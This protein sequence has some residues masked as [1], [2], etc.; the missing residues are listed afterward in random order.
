MSVEIDLADIPEHLKDQ[1]HDEFII[2]FPRTLFRKKEERWYPYSIEDGK[3]Y[4]PLAEGYKRFTIKN[5]HKTFDRKPFTFTRELRDYQ[6]REFQ[7]ILKYLETT[8]VCLVSLKTGGG[9]TLLTVALMAHLGLNTL[10]VT[11]RGNI[12]EQWEETIDESTIDKEPNGSN[13]DSKSLGGLDKTFDQDSLSV[14]YET[15]SSSS[16]QLDPN[17][18]IHFVSA[19]IFTKLPRS[20]FEGIGLLIIDEAHAMLTEKSIANFLKVCPEYVLALT[21]TPPKG[22]KDPKSK[23]VNFFFGYN[24]IDLKLYVPG[25][26]VYYFNTSFVP[27]TTKTKQ[28]YLSWDSV[29][30]S[31]TYSQEYNDFIVD[32]VSY[33]PTRNIIILCKMKDQARYLYEK[34]KANGDTVDVYYG[35]QKS[36]DSTARVLVTTVSKSGVGFNHPKL[37]MLIMACD[38]E[39]LFLQ[40]LGR[41][42]RRPD[43]LPIIID[44]VHDLK[45]LNDHWKTRRAVYL[46]TG[47]KIMDFCKSYKE[48]FVWRENKG[49]PEIIFEDDEEEINTPGGSESTIKPT[50][51]ESPCDIKN[52]IPEIE[53]ID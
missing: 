34:I 22:A 33:F 47:G 43:V 27:E 23:I 20:L 17:V 41:V 15:L 32:L 42:F 8:S 12:K 7:N 3:I 37:D 9:K 4:L 46:E 16:T 40:Y 26:P 10:V 50:V 38:V 18:R 2:R 49:K 19:A 31:I 36:Y 45:Q 25:Y 52:K 11:H 53:F 5:D 35:T 48:F 29:L 39:E 51:P 1:I 30:K 13:Q 44:I 21:A 28:G 24:K 14:K 6:A